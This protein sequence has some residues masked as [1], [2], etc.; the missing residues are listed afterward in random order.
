MRLD[1]LRPGVEDL[2]DAICAGVRS[3]CTYAGAHTLEEFHELVVLGVQSAPASPRV[4]RCPAAV[5]RA[6]A[7][8]RP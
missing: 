3:S 4:V 6:N 2:L 5:T 7:V 1:P 8:R